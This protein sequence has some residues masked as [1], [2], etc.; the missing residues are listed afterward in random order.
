MATAT[1]PAPVPPPVVEPAPAPVASALV[2][3]LMTGSPVLVSEYRGEKLRELGTLDKETGK[4]KVRRIVEMA[5]ESD[6]A[7][8]LQQCTVAI[9]EDDRSEDGR[10]AFAQ[11]LNLSKTARKKGCIVAVA[12][13]SYARKGGSTSVSADVSG[14]WVLDTA[15]KAVLGLL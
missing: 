11:F 13:R 1:A 14:I 12:V 3:L 8:G 15:S 2:R 9:W 6:D 10:A 4:A 7:D 5:L